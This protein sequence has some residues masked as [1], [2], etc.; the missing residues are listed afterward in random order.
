MVPAEMFGGTLSPSQTAPL[1]AGSRLHSS[2][3]LTLMEKIVS[4]CEP[5]CWDPRTVLKEHELGARNVQLDAIRSRND[6][7]G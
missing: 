2:N 5:G 4:G 3:R 1:V 6:M 7:V